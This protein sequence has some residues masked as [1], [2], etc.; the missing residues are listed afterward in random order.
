MKF[1][2]RAIFLTLLITLGSYGTSMGQI[3]I[4]TFVDSTVGTNSL[5]GAFTLLSPAYQNTNASSASEFE[6]L[7]NT[8]NFDIGILFAQN[9]GAND[10]LSAVTALHGFVGSGGSAL[11]VDWSRNDSLAG[12]FGATF[13]G[14]INQNQFSAPA[15]GF[16]NPVNLTN[17]GWGTYSTGLV[18]SAG[19]TTLATFANGEAAIVAGNDGRSLVLGMLS[20]TFSDPN[21]GAQLLA[22][23]I[24]YS[25]NFTPIP[26]PG[27]IAAGSMF[28]LL[29]GFTA[30][31]RFRSRRNVSVVEA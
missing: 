28:A 23:A 18:P 6:T 8:G 3:Q 5:S 25:F 12:P 22:S 15:L 24:E 30:W 26:E 9:F 4:L 1:K 16:P 10:Y 29:A 14:N 19:S 17:P 11:Y 21:E 13:T 2:L 7:L 27:T 31:R 20:D